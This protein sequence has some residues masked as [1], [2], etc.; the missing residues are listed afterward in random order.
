MALAS[1]KKE[2]SLSHTNLCC[3]KYSGGRGHQGANFGA[4]RELG[5]TVWIAELGRNWAVHTIH[6]TAQFA[7]VHEL[8]VNWAIQIRKNPRISQFTVEIPELAHSIPNSRLLAELCTSFS[9]PE[10]A[11]QELGRIGPIHSIQKWAP[12]WWGWSEISESFFHAFF[13]KTG[14]RF[15]RVRLAP[16]SRS[17][18]LRAPKSVLPD[19]APNTFALFFQKFC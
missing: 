8:G 1:R 10:L 11:I 17:I 9:I 16:K 7:T 3:K 14:L 12:W 4:G 5:R 18:N 6:W 13:R 2:L 15:L 19:L